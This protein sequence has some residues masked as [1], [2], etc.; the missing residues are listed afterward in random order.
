MTHD[1]SLTPAELARVR[2]AFDDAMRTSFDA[3]FA[4]PE[5]ALL[6]QALADGKAALL[7]TRDTVRVVPVVEE[8]DAEKGM[9]VPRPPGG[10]Q[11]QDDEPSWGGYL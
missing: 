10:E 4:A 8:F 11:V 5:I 2:A 9:H 7:V 6:V 3:L 1:S